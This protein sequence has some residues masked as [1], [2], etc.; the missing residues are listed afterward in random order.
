MPLPCSEERACSVTVV[1]PTAE[2][3]S[4]AFPGHVKDTERALGLLGGSDRI[5]NTL[6]QPG[7]PLKCRPRGAVRLPASSG[8]VSGLRTVFTVA[9]H[10]QTHQVPPR[11]TVKYLE[12]LRPRG[13]HQDQLDL[14][15]QRSGSLLPPGLI[16]TLTANSCRMAFR[17]RF[18]AQHPQQ[19]ACCCK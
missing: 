16:D 5:Y 6:R 3:S 19:V 13:V 12:R 10:L 8:C 15:Q 4:I 9:M 17:T 14:A 18:T 7:V 2:A 11:A 1:V